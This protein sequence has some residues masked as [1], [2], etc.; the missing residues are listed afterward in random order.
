MNEYGF[1]QGIARNASESEYPEVWT[2]LA[3]L[4]APEAGVQGGQLVD[5]VGRNNVSLSGAVWTNGRRGP[6]VGFNGSS[7]FG[8]SVGNAGAVNVAGPMTVCAW[9]SPSATPGGFTEIVDK[10]NGNNGFSLIIFSDSKMQFY[11]GNGASF[12]GV[13]NATTALQNGR[14]YFVCGRYNGSVAQ[15]FV[16]GLSEGSSVSVAS[17]GSSSGVAV[18]IASRLV[19]GTRDRFFNGRIGAIYLYSRAISQAEIMQ[20]YLGAS[21]LVRKQE[22]PVYHIVSGGAPII[23]RNRTGSRARQRLAA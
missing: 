1:A 22:N 23:F 11:V 19:S 21:P 3:A 17:M 9:I 16:N 7:M 14:W 20:L 12:L 10:E 8:V 18:Q 4:W 6:A 15:V 2:R 5:F 13:S